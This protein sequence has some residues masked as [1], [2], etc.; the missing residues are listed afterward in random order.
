M[1]LSFF[2][3]CGG[4]QPKQGE[5]VSDPVPDDLD[6]VGSVG[7]GLAVVKRIVAG[8][9][10]QVTF[11]TGPGGTTTLRVRLPVTRMY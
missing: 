6:A 5:H 3:T 11:D 10:G 4:L 2:D 7:L 9:E 8:Y 1:V